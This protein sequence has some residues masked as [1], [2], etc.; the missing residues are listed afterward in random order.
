M[1]WGLSFFGKAYKHSAAGVG[2][3]P[4]HLRGLNVGLKV[5]ECSKMLYKDFNTEES[6]PPLALAATPV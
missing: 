1:S 4:T 6:P 5:Q 2:Y 3:T